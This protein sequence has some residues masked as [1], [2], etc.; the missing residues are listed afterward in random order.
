[1]TKHTWPVLM[2]LCFLACMVTM[3]KGV[4]FDL[5]E[6]VWYLFELSAVGA[7]VFWALWVWEGRWL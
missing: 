5:L 3:P 6:P 4:P 7:L 2:F 1:M